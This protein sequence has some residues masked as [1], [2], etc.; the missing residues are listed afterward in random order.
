MYDRETEL[1][2]LQSR[3]YNPEWGRFINADNYPSTG[4]GL[5]G[6]NMFVYC[7]NNPVARED[8]GGEFWNIVIGA[9][10][11]ALIS[12][13]TT[14]IDSYTT[15]GS[16]DWAAVGISAAVGAISGG[17]AATGLGVIAQAS[18]SAAASALG[19]V[20]T[21]IHELSQNPNSDGITW[22]E[23][24]QISLRAIGSAAIGF[25]GSVFG[26]AAGKAVTSGLEAQGA[27][28]VFR[29]KIGAGCM[30][31]AQAR[32]MVKQGK[33]LINTARGVSSVVGSVFVWPTATA[34][35]FGLS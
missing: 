19:S 12:A 29:G 24:G 9:T 35:S 13:A 14:A 28:M 7:G 32:N 27:N 11:G 26:T 23:V 34:F 1:Y 17:V 20:A 31:K 18:I 4:Q 30:T 8:D 6:N 25:G 15:T 3:Y 22:S 2:Y 16:I 21:D 5:L 33:A 10:V